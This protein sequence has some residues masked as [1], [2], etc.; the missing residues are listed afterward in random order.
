MALRG[1]AN[2]WHFQFALCLVVKVKQ[3]RQ[4]I[5]DTLREVGEALETGEFP[6]REVIQSV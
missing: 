2:A 5:I 3:G 6:L 1:T 4:G